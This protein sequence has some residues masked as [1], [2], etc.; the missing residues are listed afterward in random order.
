MKNDDTILIQRTLAGDNDAFSDLVKKYQRQVHV[1]AWRKTGDFHIAEDI[2]QETFIKAFQRLHTLKEP[3]RFAGWLYVIAARG[4]LAWFR[5]K[6]LAHKTLENIDIPITD[7][8]AY[9]RH[10]VEE[11]TKSTKMVQQE[12]VKQ[13]LETL[14]E[15]DRTV[16]TLYY[17]GEMTC[18]EISQFLGVS[19]NTIKSRL[20]RA[21]N[22]LKQE[23]PMIREAITNFQISPKLTEN[24][25]QEITR[26]IPI[27]PSTGKPLTPW[28][29]G[30]TSAVLIVLMLGTGSQLL[31]RF[32]KHYSLDVSSEA[33]VELI[34][35]PI[36]LNLD[37]K[38]DVRRQFGNLSAF[39]RNNHSGKKPNE[40]QLTAAQAE[41]EN[42]PGKN[43]QWIQSEP[44][45]GS[46]VI[47]MLA[48]PKGELYAFADRNIYTL[49]TDGKGW[50]HTFD[51]T[52]LDTNYEGEGVM[53]KWGDSL[54]LILS[55]D[56]FVSTDNGKTW[57][58]VYSWREGLWFPVE[59]V[60]TEQ[61][62]YLLFFLG[63]NAHQTNDLF[64]SEDS[65]K[66][67]EVINGQIDRHI[68]TIVNIQNTLFARTEYALYR[69][70]DN[71]WQRLE[72]PVSVG[73]IRSVAVAD[74]KL[75]VMAEAS[76]DVLDSGKVSQGL[77]RGWWIFRSTN[78]GDSWDDITPTN[79]W[80]IK[81]L[82]PRL[83]LI[84]AGDT[85]L[86]MEHGMICSTDSG[87]TWVASQLSDPA[88][89]INAYEAIKADDGFSLAVNERIFYVNGRN[90]LHR[91]VDSGKSWNKV[92][93]NTGR[94]KIDVLITG[95]GSEKRH[96]M[97][98]PLYAKYEGRIATSTDEG[99]SWNSVQL[100]IPMTDH[101]REKPPDITYITK[102]DGVLYAKGGGSY[103][104]GNTQIYRVSTE[105][106]MLIPIQGM[107]IYD[108]RE[109]SGRFANIMNNQF[110]MPDKPVIEQMQEQI[111]GANQF[112]TQLVQTDRENQFK[113][114]FY[115]LRGPFAVSGD[116]FYMDYNYKL[117]Q[118]KLGDTEWSN[119]GVEE[120][121][122]LTL[123]IA[124]KKPKL[125]ISGDT[126]YVG[127]RD[128]HLVVSYDR[129]NNWIDLTPALPFPV[130][131][132]N[133][134]AVA[135]SAVYVATDAGSITSE[136]GR[137]WRIVTDAKGTNIIMKH[138]A[139]DATK[140]Y[141]VTKDIGIY[142]IG[143]DVWEQVVS[144]IPDNVTSLAVDGNTLYIATQ[145][146]G[147][148]RY[149]LE[150]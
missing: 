70:T 6:R 51:T 147:M 134:I 115:G 74:Q 25:I 53:K 4:C 89:S 44:I 86:G 18:E 135:D 112:H 79:A 72:F 83:K 34:D 48:T 149:I 104:R 35:V 32:H 2:T 101:N 20:R 143:S 42:I 29:I 122:E 28:I 117:F 24:I 108:I 52:A 132:F 14:K 95:K 13:L 111:P 64:R 125:A 98:M 103:N 30:A 54:Y 19:A 73:K 88:P 38:P 8:D 90:G 77:E 141:G 12:V 139:V 145:S 137:H 59:M 148:L 67:W 116:T 138:L 69:F 49:D 68:Y 120:T 56:L 47:S 58:L 22:R 99:K 76:D 124:L 85:L 5:K 36:V 87:N 41:G 71:N 118:W 27:T 131:T 128:G 114:F 94:S 136:N 82:P 37:A 39:D 43:Q 123:D 10:I 109:L 80:P 3:Q 78:L 133:E 102:S 65:G 60:L 57:D 45:R 150:N 105:G 16:I 11:K 15:S 121:G 142:R 50:R 91:S 23:E 127:K 17:F 126:V 9:S 26:L 129:G 140:V 31:A 1:L 93:I 33:T 110:N 106:N 55:T 97:P 7:K 100:E 21:R 40:V 144:E 119:T 61:A 92:N 96:K 81:G 46:N 107:P 62:Y 146:Q 63:N 84:A 113:L 130:E 66:T 75:Y